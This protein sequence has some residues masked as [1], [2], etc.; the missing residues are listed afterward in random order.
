[1]NMRTRSD[2]LG[3]LK[4]VIHFPCCPKEKIIVYKNST[5]RTSNK[6]PCCGKIAVF[7]LD[8]MTATASAPIRGAVH[9]FKTA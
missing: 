8:H 9:K 6:C 2:Q 4:D 5:G 7:N 1:M 3:D